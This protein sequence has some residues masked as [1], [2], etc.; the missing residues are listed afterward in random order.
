MKINTALKTTLLLVV[1]TTGCIAFNGYGQT[2]P[3]PEYPRPQFERTDWINLN[4]TWSYTFDF[5]KSGIERDL[6]NSQG[7]KDKI[8]VPFCP[9]SK[10]SGVGFTDF[11]EAMWYQRK[12]EIPD[13]WNG[14]RVI[15]HFGGVDYQSNLYIDGKPVGTHFGG[16]S[17]FN[18]DITKFVTAGKSHNLVLLVN[19][20]VRSG[21]QPSGKQ[22]VNLKSGGCN[23]TRT[24]GIWQTVWLEAVAKNGIQDCFVL[25]DLDNS[26]FV[27][28]PRF[29]GLERGMKL[30][31]K[32]LDG[33]KMVAQQEMAAAQNIPCE[34][35]LKNPKTWSPESP[36]LYDVIYQVIDKQSVV[37][38]EVKGYAG[39]RKV[40]IEGDKLYLNNKPVF[41][42]FVLD[43][44][45]YPEGI[46]T[47]P[48]D[49]ALKQDIQLS[50]DAGFNGARLH[51]KVF[52]QRFHYW[53]DKL[54]Y[55][56]WGES[57]SWGITNNS[58]ESARNFLSEWNE[59]VLRDRSF[60]S[61]IGW[62]PFNETSGS[63]QHNRMI[64]DAYTATK[65][66]DPTR[67]VNDASG[68]FH[69]ITDLY[70]AHNYEQNPEALRKQLT[71]GKNSPVFNNNLKQAPYEGQPY[72]LDEYGGIKWVAGSAF[73][74]NTWGYGDGPKTLE[75]YY[76]RLEKLTDVIL[77]FD[78][79]SGYCYTQ[80]TDV[81]QE[82]NGVY[83]YNR[84]SKF[85]M[86]RVKK[87]FSKQPA[88]FQ[89]NSK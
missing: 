89:N 74:E 34:I 16:T 26:K 32:L 80:L 49:A 75:E 29:Y 52:E 21:Q 55:L 48:T 39:M 42:R 19:D 67:P 73:A 60:P 70:T 12:I 35:A 83:N 46:W 87:I 57:S 23:Y 15:L 18:Y 58:I 30:K 88:S 44:G 77:S 5:S 17:S 8:I 6:P 7:F 86:S 69:V 36:F 43:Q 61:I 50:M 2:Q 11:I 27:F 62:S 41:L 4:G 82:Q 9:E 10:L 24:T 68:Y 54:G 56:T 1:M 66:I 28:Q 72:F 33:I 53:A 71:P 84:T 37:I 76:D 13:S 45:F 3:R 47:A 40:H 78:Y 38:D 65:M 22:C 64:T 20:E 51:Q 25:P 81:E 14:K 31:I 79:M 59:I 63:V 85:D